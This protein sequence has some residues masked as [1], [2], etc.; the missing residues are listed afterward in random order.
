MNKIKKLCYLGVMALFFVSCSSDF[1]YE[2]SANSLIVTQGDVVTELTV[3]SDEIIRV[4]KHLASAAE[5]VIPEWVVTMRPQ[6]VDWKLSERGGKLR[7]KTKKIT[8]AINEAGEVSYTTNSGEPIVSE[9]AK[10]SYMK[11]NSERDYAMAQVFTVG[12]EALYGLGQFQSGLM[13]WRNTPVRLQQSN[14]EIAVPFMLSTAGYGIYWGNYSVTEFNLPDNE[15]VFTEVVDKEQK[16]KRAKFTPRM[17][18][19]Y[20]FMV[21][22]PTPKGNRRLGAMNLLMDGDTVLT[23]TTMWFPDAISG[24]ME[25]QAGREYEVLYQDTGA[26]VDGKVLYNE[27]NYNQTKF[28]NE[29]GEAIDYYLIYGERPTKVLDL[30]TDLTGKAPMFPKSAYGF[31]HCREAYREQETLLENAREYRKRGIPVDNIVQDWD[32][33]PKGTRAPEWDRTRYPDPKAMVDELSDLNMN[34]LVS[35]WPAVDNKELV[36]RYDLDKL[37]GKSYINAYDTS[38]ST[39]FYRMLSDSMYKIGVQAIWIDG[40]E[41]ATE[42]SQSSETGFGV[43]EQVANIYSQRV[44]HGV[45]NGHREEFPRERSINLTRS[46]F[47]GQQRYGA[48]VWSGDV[49]GSWEQFREQIPAGLNTTVAGIPYWTTDIGGFFRNM[50]NGNTVERDQYNDP[51][52]LELLTRWFEYGTFCPIFRIHGFKSQ[53]EVWRYGADFEAVARKYINLRYQLMPYIYSEAHR[54]TTSGSAMMSPLA[55]HYPA[56]Q[57]V[58]DIED[59]FMFGESM[60]ISPVVEY[61][62]RTREL[63]LPSGEWYNM[64]NG[65]RVKGGRRFTAMAELG[66][67]PIYIKAGA[68]IPYGAKIQYATEPTKKPITLRVYPGA[69]GEFE[70]YFDDNT[71]YDYEQG[72]YSTIIIRWDDSQGRLTLKSGVDGYV[73][74]ASNP[75]AFNLEFVGSNRKGQIVFNGREVEL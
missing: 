13:N 48:M 56:D 68:I 10:G 39:N 70:L 71:T 12:D 7:I 57:N 14:Q 22:S 23:Y 24:R 54:V 34:L 50:T 65:E 9:I 42:P 35:V 61:K 2:K 36:A 43:Y 16:I 1:N 63:Y 19:V 60:L 52:Y 5:P 75:I 27:P 46:G 21:Q 15:I 26:Q 32:Y 25:L 6:G 49:D 40:S 31:W 20:N 59:Q 29:H 3:M 4:R 28:S 69:D 44:L 18:G 30:Y 74:F 37:D 11:A 62:A 55:Y 41:P 45:Y 33:W 58:W 66:Q 8:A 67:M 47:S 51:D 38:I 73:D 53:T 64:W 72:K 17:S